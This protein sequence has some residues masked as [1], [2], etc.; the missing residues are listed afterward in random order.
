M[1]NFCD[2]WAK[3]EAKDFMC[4]DIDDYTESTKEKVRSNEK[5]NWKKNSDGHDVKNRN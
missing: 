5:R 1:A 4:T 2:V 3:H